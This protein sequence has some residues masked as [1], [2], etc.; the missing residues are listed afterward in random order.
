ML[1]FIVL[2][3]IVHTYIPIHLSRIKRVEQHD[4]RS[5]ISVK[6]YQNQ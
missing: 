6:N 3:G 5:S 4:F 2:V 1:I